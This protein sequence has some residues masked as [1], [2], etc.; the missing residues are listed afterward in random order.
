MLLQYEA[1]LI[2]YKNDP[3]QLMEQLDKDSNDI[4]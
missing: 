2:H 3:L 1:I 4:Y